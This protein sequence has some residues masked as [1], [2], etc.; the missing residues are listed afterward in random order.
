[1][2]NN[3]TN[4]DLYNEIKLFIK[5]FIYEAEKK[6]KIK[7]NDNIE[8][9]NFQS[10]I[11]LRPNISFLN[12]TVQITD[13]A[14]LY[15]KIFNKNRISV[16]LKYN[17]KFS[18]LEEDNNSINDDFIKKIYFYF[19]EVNQNNPIKIKTLNIKNF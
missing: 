4:N 2:K 15:I 16:L 9:L 3:I 11:I 10:K 19:E 8:T 5:Y 1:M 18:N 13:I 14:D 12:C 7:H 17:N 6:D